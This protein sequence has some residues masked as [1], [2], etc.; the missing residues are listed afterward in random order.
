MLKKKIKWDPCKEQRPVQIQA[1]YKFITNFFN[2]TIRVCHK[3]H[4]SLIIE[5]QRY[6]ATQLAKP[7]KWGGEREKERGLTGKNLAVNLQL[8]ETKTTVLSWPC[9][10]LN[11]TRDIEIRLVRL[12]L[13]NLLQNPNNMTPISK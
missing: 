9:K 8:N 1:Y 13:L 10:H 4:Q 6:L 3:T 12:K 7:K 11:K 5:F 2:T